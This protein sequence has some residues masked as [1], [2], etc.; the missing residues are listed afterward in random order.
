[1]TTVMSSGPG[2]FWA[3][4]PDRHPAIPAGG[5]RVH[6]ARIETYDLDPSVDDLNTSFELLVAKSENN[7]QL[8]KALIAL[9]Q[10]LGANLAILKQ[11][12]GR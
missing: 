3:E 5:L 2:F 8:A 11:E 9:H 12:A 4:T 1:M 10:A 7:P 6:C